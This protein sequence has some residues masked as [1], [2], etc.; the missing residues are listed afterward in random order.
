MWI[1]LGVGVDDGRF[2]ATDRD[3]LCRSARDGDFEI[4]LVPRHDP[5]RT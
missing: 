4:E 1:L 2:D 5:V 3:R